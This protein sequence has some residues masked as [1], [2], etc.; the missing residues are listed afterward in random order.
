ARCPVRVYDRGAQRDRPAKCE[1]LDCPYNLLT[2]LPN[3]P[4]CKLL[5]CISNQL[6]SLP[7]LPP[8]SAQRDR[9]ANCKYF[10]CNNNQLISED[11][12]FWIKFNQI[13]SKIIGK[14]IIRRWKR[15]VI[16]MEI[17]EQLKIDIE[18]HPMTYRIKE[19][20]LEISQ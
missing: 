5:Y 2:S 17:P 15:F 20:I 7:D 10:N 6:T 3:L 12:D 16:K 9:P 11:K 18:Y 19:M 8:R 4:N 13:K 1:E 14:R